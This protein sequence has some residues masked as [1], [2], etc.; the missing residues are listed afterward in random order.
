MRNQLKVKIVKKILFSFAIITVLF[1][2]SET[3]GKDEEKIELGESYGPEE[4]DIEKAIS[5]EEFFNDFEQKD[6]PESYTI[7]GKIV[8]ICS[9]AGCWVGIDNGHD[10]YFMVR[11]KDHFT[12]PLDTEIDTYAYIHGIATW[13]SITVKQLRDDAMDAG[14]SKEEIEA[15]T[16]PE[17]SFDFVADGITLKK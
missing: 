15:I 9:K 12:I 3:E 4:V 2:C 8:E 6:G 13:D 17:Y 11:F 7:E 16:Q 10:D 1:S 14:K 5:I